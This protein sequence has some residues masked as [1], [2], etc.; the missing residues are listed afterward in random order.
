MKF[1]K[2]HYRAQVDSKDCGVAA[3][4]MVLEYYNSHYSLAELREMLGTTENG[5]TAFSIVSVA[6]ELG[7]D[8]EAIYADISLFDIE[9]IKF[10]FIVHINK[11]NKF[12]HYYVII[13]SDKKYIYIA[14]PDPLIKLSKLT[15]EQFLAEW[16][17]ITILLKPNHEYKIKR[18]KTSFPSLFTLLFNQKKL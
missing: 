7:F 13:G 18:K 2:R 15:K 6:N 14:D 4:A 10:P 11:N 1:S 3:L 16:R 12:Y 17:G 5:T 8:T 9:D